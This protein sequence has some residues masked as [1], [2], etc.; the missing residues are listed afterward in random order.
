MMPSRYGYPYILSSL[1]VML[2]GGICC[3][4]GLLQ[5]L[6]GSI[7]VIGMIGSLF[8]SA[9]FRDP[10]RKAPAN[11]ATIL[12]PADGKVV[13]IDTIESRDYLRSKSIRISIFLSLLDVHVN[14]IPSD[15][16]IEYIK[17]VPGRFNPAHSTPGSDLNEHM[18]VG[19][20]TKHHKMMI[21]QIAGILTRRIICRLREGMKVTRGSRYGMIV[22][23]SRTDLYVPLGTEICVKPG[24]SVKGGLS[25][26]GVLKNG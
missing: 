20:K 1:I 3:L 14:R 11:Q 17:Y 22:F 25:I 26:I 12:S 4:I 21:V 16:K 8:F 5:P 2:S 7:A 10:E 19:I 24:D 15:G 6:T 18:V 23:G 13:A 9:F